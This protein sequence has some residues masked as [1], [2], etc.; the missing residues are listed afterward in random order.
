MSLCTILEPLGKEGPQFLHSGIFAFPFSNQISIVVSFQHEG[1]LPQR[2]IFVPLF[3]N[4]SNKESFESPGLFFLP[5]FQRSQD[6][7]FV[8]DQ[9][10]RVTSFLSPENVC[11]KDVFPK[12]MA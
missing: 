3:Y 11:K 8:K 10:Q 2:G 7:F 9:D 12:D 1:C 5:R 4:T 6:K